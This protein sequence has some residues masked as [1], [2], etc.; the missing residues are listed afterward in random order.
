MSPEE[1][2]DDDQQVTVSDNDVE[3]INEEVNEDGLPIDP[4]PKMEDEHG[5][6]EN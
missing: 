1:E 2:M 5:V 4:N 3:M 6:I